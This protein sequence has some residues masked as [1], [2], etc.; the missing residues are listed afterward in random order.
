MCQCP[1]RASTYFFQIAELT[2]LSLSTMCQC[3]QRASTYF[4]CRKIIYNK[5]DNKKCQ[6][7]Q[8]ASTYFFI[9]CNPD[10]PPICACQCPQRASTYFFNRIYDLRSKMYVSMPST[11]FYLFLLIQRGNY[12]H[13]NDWCQCPQRAS[14]YFFVHTLIEKSS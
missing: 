11:G 9:N 13:H 3:P 4:F 14:T 6:C 1:Q 8:R 2:N 12:K 7:P 10:T 5:S